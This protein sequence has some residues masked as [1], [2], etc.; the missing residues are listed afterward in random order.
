MAIIRPFRAIRPR[1]ELA[2]KVAALPYDVM[3]TEEA[4][5]MADGN[6]YSFLHVSRAE[7][8]LDPSIDPHSSAV[9][10]K[11]RENFNRLIKDGILFQDPQPCYYLYSLVMNGRRQT[12]IVAC[13]SIDDYFNN[14]I[15]KHEHTRPEK[16]QDRIDHM[17]ALQAHSGPVFLTYRKND[18]L[19]AVVDKVMMQQSPVYDFSAPDRVRHTVWVIT[20][21]T[22]IQHISALFEQ[23][24]SATYI[25][26]GHHRAASSAKV[27]MKLRATNPHHTGNEEYNFFLT[28]L[29]PHDQLS[30][31]DYN[32]VI[33]DLNHL[34]PEELIA[35]IRE[36][37]DVEE[38]IF[39]MARPQRPREFAMYLNKKWYRLTAKPG[40]WRNDPIGTLDITILSENILAPILNITDQRT[41]RRI[42]F[43]GG[44][45]G[46]KELE[47]RVNNGDM[48]LAFALYPVSLQQ[49]MDISDS[50]QVMPP[51]STWF[52]PKLRDG[53]FIHAF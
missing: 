19:N 4:R 32:R 14:I 18:E 41:D 36:K 52:E 49:L 28:V 38:T 9:Y 20:D 25:A 23:E 53:L 16:E 7:I 2:D 30:I 24:V 1:T 11:A 31:M 35:R 13:S 50:G 44:I 45:R 43:V 34:S 46:L 5:S 42:D 29:F 51:K 48:Q 8:D 21:A 3:N 22:K 39:E 17:L 40:I 27:G 37:F 33:K 12:G 15:R 10:Q 6:P 47:R 26:D